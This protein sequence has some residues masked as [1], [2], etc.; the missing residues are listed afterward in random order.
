TLLRLP[1]RPGDR[2]GAA[3]DRRRGSGSHGRHGHPWNGRN[4]CLG[5]EDVTSHFADGLAASTREN[6]L[7]R[8]GIKTSVDLKAGEPFI[9]NYIQGV[10]RVP[11]GFAAVKSLEFSPG[12]VTFISTTGLRVIAPLKHEFLKTGKLL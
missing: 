6:A 7:T 10:V 2:R 9:V 5:L 1:H 4:N 3:G 12:E 11:A 8:E